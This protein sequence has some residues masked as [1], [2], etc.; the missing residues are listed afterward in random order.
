MKVEDFSEFVKTA[1]KFRDKTLPILDEIL[2]SGNIVRLSN[3]EQNIDLETEENFGDGFTVPFAEFEKVVQKVKTGDITISPEDDL[4]VKVSTQKGVFTFVGQEPDDFPKHTSV[5]EMTHITD[6]CL[7]EMEKIKKAEVF[8]C[9]DDLRPAMCSVL[10]DK[11]T[12]VGTDAHTLS[13]YPSAKERDS[14]FLIDNKIAKHISGLKRE[15]SVFEGGKDNN[16]IAFKVDNLSIVS[17]KIDGTFPNYKAVIPQA[18]DKEMVL[19]SKNFLDALDVAE[20]SLP[21]SGLIVLKEKDGKI[22]IR[23][24]D[25]DFNKSFSCELTGKGIGDSF[26]IG[27]KCQFM[28]NILK[29]ENSKST[30]ITFSTPNRAMIINDHVLLM[31]LIIND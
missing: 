21:V 11:D 6:L 10:V 22:S 15:V 28:K 19:D 2:F 18:N 16:F 30:K 5:S 26:E 29:T 17:R 12:I 13:F 8:S 7:E 24:E 23:T 4:K 31:P 25:L 27:F 3:L 14:S 20:I 1:K 9:K